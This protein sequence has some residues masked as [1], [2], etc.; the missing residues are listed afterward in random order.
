MVVPSFLRGNTSC[1]EL[2]LD[3][4]EPDLEV[5]GPIRRKLDVDGC[6]CRARVGLACAFDG[7]RIKDCRSSRS[8]IEEVRWLCTSEQR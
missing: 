3:L 6:H 1:G 4:G 2:S 5:R 7:H 8:P